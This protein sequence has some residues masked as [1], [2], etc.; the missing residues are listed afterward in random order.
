MAS[1]FFFFLNAVKGNGLVF[2]CRN[3][4]RLRSGWARP[5]PWPLLILMLDIGSFHDKLT[6]WHSKLTVWFMTYTVCAWI[7]VPFL[8][9]S[10]SHDITQALFHTIKPYTSFHTPIYY[11]EFPLTLTPAVL[12]V[13]SSPLHQGVWF[14]QVRHNRDRDEMGRS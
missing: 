14:V 3:W 11:N 5:V 7:F 8:S 10:D 4:M 6:Q 12:T 13:F 1:L 9:F 2:T